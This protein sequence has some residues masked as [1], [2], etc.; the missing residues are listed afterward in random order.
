MKIDSSISD[1]GFKK[2]KLFDCF[3]IDNRLFQVIR[4]EQDIICFEL[5]VQEPQDAM[6]LN[7]MKGLSL[8]NLE[9]R[10]PENHKDNLMTIFVLDFNNGIIEYIPGMNDVHWIK[11]DDLAFW[12]NLA[13]INIT[14]DDKI[15]WLLDSEMPER[16]SHELCMLRSRMSHA[17]MKALDNAQ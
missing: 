6:L 5:I 8:T 14:T 3:C 13:Q 7:N 1:Q 16:M 17:V 9:I 12:V 15:L 4:I 10:I 11:S 2:T